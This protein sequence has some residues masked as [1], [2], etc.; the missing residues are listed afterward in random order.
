MA[1]LKVMLTIQQLSLACG[2]L[3][4]SERSSLIE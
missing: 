3:N 1:L 2:E 4:L